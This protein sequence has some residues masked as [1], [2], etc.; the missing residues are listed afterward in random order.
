MLIFSGAN[1]PVSQLPD[2]ARIIS[3]IFPLTHGIEAARLLFTDFREGAFWMLLLNEFAV[4][5]SY[6]LIALIIMKF[7][8]RVAVKNANFDLF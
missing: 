2:W 8:E 1:F 4:G 5:V 7:A 3:K 6:F